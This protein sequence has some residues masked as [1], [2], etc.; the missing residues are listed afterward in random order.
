[1]NQDIEIEARFLVCGDGWRA[2]GAAVEIYQGYL[3]TDENMAIR[4][5]I[6][7]NT[8]TLAI[9]GKTRGL[10][11]KEFEFGLTDTRKA[12]KVID[13]FCDHPI[14]KVRY[15]IKHGD[16][17]WEV[18]EYKGEN[19]GLVVAE[20][21]FQYEDEYRKMLE[22]GKPSW[23]G[24]EITHSAWQYTNACLSVRPFSMWRMEE[25][26]DMLTHAASKSSE[27]L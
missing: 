23:V 8:A 22:V 21:E 27:C 13:E 25:K 15:T 14:Q 26:K 9:K 19:Q 2:K 20:I 7:E 12:Q 11:R 16:F 1:M 10:T 17:S 24:K 3:V 18:D 6:S 4:I 5:R